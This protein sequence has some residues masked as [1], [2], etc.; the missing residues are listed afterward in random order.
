MIPCKFLYC[1]NS[2]RVIGVNAKDSINSQIW[3]G[4]KLRLHHLRAS[5]R[6]IKRESIPYKHISS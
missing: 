1:D 4:T 5:K 3:W 2:C 6:N